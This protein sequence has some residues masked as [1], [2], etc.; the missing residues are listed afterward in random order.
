MDRVVKHV[1]I[2]HNPKVRVDDFL[3]VLK[4]GFDRHQISSEVFSGEAPAQCEYILTY[5]ALRSWDWSPY[6]AHAELSLKDKNREVARAV[7][8]HEGGLSL[9]KWQQ[10][11][12]KMDPVIDELL[13]AYGQPQRGGEPATGS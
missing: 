13:G 3:D 11:K 2:Q 7:Y 1:C 5:T 10:T 12:T 6:L 4:K 8:N 9:M